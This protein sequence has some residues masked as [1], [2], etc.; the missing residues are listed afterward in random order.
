MF[1][2]APPVFFLC[3]CVFNIFLPQQKSLGKKKGE[4]E[5]SSLKRHIGSSKGVCCCIVPLRKTRRKEGLVDVR[6]REK[7]RTI[8]FFFDFSTLRRETRF[9]HNDSLVGI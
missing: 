9:I 2:C 7:R 5:K 3:S 6:E 4:R 8:F 1:F